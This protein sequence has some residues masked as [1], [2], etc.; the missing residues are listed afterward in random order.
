MDEMEKLIS[1]FRSFRREN[2][3]GSRSH[4]QDLVHQGQSPRIMIIAC[5]DSRVDPAIVIEKLAAELIDLARLE[6]EVGLDA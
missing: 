4:F 1:G 5:S 2:F 6:R 3:T